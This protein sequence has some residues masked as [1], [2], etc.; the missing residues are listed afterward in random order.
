MVNFDEILNVGIP[1]LLI[2]I[3]V[4][5]VYTKFLGPWLVPHLKNLWIWMNGQTLPT[6]GSNKKEI[7]YE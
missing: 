5:F 1:I 4:G 7:V 2:L 6:L 3:A